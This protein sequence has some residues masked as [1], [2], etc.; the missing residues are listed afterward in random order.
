M[1]FLL[2]NVLRYKPYQSAFMSFILIFISSPVLITFTFVR[3]ESELWWE[4]LFFIVFIAALTLMFLSGVLINFITREIEVRR[5]AF[6]LRYKLGALPLKTWCLPRSEYVAVYTPASVEDNLRSRF[7]QLRYSEADVRRSVLENNDLSGF[8]LL[9]KNR[10]GKRVFICDDALVGSLRAG[11]N[12]NSNEEYLQAFFNLPVV[13]GFQQY[14]SLGSVYGLPEKRRG[15]FL[16]KDEGGVVTLTNPTGLY[17]G[18]FISAGCVIL[19]LLGAIPWAQSLYVLVPMVLATYRE[20][21]RLDS[22]TL[23]SELSVAGLVFAK[24][25]LSLFEVV[26]VK[27]YPSILLGDHSAIVELGLKGG[28]RLGLPRGKFEESGQ[29]A[30]LSRMTMAECIWLVKHLRARLPND[31]EVIDEGGFW[32]NDGV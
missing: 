21:I 5:D 7:V 16:L 32:E 26:S 23:S 31:I 24:F 3:F 25:K 14:L 22:E 27:T 30:G 13:N 6:W 9:H 19:L 2:P 10:Y 28:K 1:E 17:A 8:W 11:T 4:W 15:V 29:M 20:R 12:Y 18:V